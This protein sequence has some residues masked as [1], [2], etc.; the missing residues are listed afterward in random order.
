MAKRVLN[1]SEAR[2]DLP[3]LVKRVA[4]GGKAVAI[5]PRGEETAVLLGIEEY[6]ALKAR[7]KGAPANSWEDLRV[8]IV[9][10]ADDVE[11]EIRRIRTDVAASLERRAQRLQERPARP[12]GS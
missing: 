6:R 11:Q 10:T 7:A 5:G 2:R 4:Q 1:V 8:E 12:R 3:R 9:G